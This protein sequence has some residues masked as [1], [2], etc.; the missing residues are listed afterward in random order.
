MHSFSWL[1]VHHVVP[2][3]YSSFDQAPPPVLALEIDIGDGGKAW[4]THAGGEDTA[5]K[6]NSDEA[7]PNLLRAL[8]T[9]AIPVRKVFVLPAFLLLMGLEFLSLA[10]FPHFIANYRPVL[11]RVRRFSLMPFSSTYRRFT[12]SQVI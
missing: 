3:A 2:V 5:F 10:R 6:V 7:A 11:G 4:H 12:I 1:V 9:H 8:D